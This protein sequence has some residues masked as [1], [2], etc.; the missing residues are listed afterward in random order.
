MGKFKPRPLITLTTDFGLQGSYVG[1]MKAAIL[2]RN[3]SVPL[4]DLSHLIP[5]QD[6]LAGALLL[7]D[8]GGRFPPG[9]IHVA[10]VDPGVGTDRRIVLAQAGEQ[11][12]LVPDNGLLTFVDRE[13]PIEQ[14]VEVTNRTYFSPEIS[15]TFHGRDIFAPVA[16][17]L[18]L[19]LSPSRLGKKVA[20]RDVQRLAV[21]EPAI[22]PASI[23]GQVL[24][25][26]SFGNLVTN[27]DASLV[28]ES[29]QAT[30]RVEVAGREIG[31]IQATYGISPPQTLI[32]LWGSSGRLEVAVVGGN[33]ATLLGL[34][35]GAPVVVRF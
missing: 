1:Q 24:Q 9:T 5:P 3:P 17:H 28:T 16:A 8:C 22:G 33:A 10:V 13:T 12:Y 27:I 18:S 29:Q 20:P 23:A 25:I 30:A 7:A 2:A 34:G 31:G 14:V 11:F 26:D 15:A 32:A 19:G 4:V 21:V 35:R 6:V